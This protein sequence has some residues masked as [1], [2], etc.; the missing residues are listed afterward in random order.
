VESVALAVLVGSVARVESVALAVLVGSVARV[1]WAVLV[2]IAC[3]P[4]QLAVVAA[5]GNTTHNIAVELRIET[6]QRQT[7]LG[8]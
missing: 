1:A 5:T 2:T 3:Q 8:A 7:G 4:C 6:G